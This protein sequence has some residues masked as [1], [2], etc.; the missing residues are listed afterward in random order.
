MAADVHLKDDYKANVRGV[1]VQDG[2]VI[3]GY[4]GSKGKSNH[5]KSYGYLRAPEVS[6]IIREFI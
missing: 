5:H 3:N 1:R 4:I 6:R 2:L